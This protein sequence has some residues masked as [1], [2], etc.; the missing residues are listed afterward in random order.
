MKRWIF[1][2]FAIVAA[3]LFAL[4]V[5]GGRWWSLGGV[6]VGPFGALQCFGGD[7]CTAT[8]LGW[9]GDPRWQRIGM[10]A[11]TGGLIAAASLLAFAAAFASNRAPVLLARLA[12]VAVATAAIAGA[13]FIALAP[14][15][16]ETE[17][18]VFERGLVMFVAAVAIGGGLATAQLLS[19]RKKSPA[20][21]TTPAP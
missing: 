14:S 10:G 19:L 12:A 17:S 21:A 7:Q 20:L 16:S 18:R 2:A 13:A 4:S 9:L 5:Q 1:V 11:W 15:I 6:H 8:G 3:S